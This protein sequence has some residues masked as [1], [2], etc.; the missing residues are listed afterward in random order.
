M[1]LQPRREV[2]EYGLLPLHAACPQL[3]GALTLAH[4]HAKL[5]ASSTPTAS[6]QRVIT[7]PAVAAALELTQT[8]TEAL[9]EVLAPLSVLNKNVDA[10][11][12]Q[13]FVHELSLFLFTQLFGREAQRP[14]S[15]EV[16]FLL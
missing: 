15:V 4:M 9:L 5:L 6:G 1:Q 14:D 16:R 3:D 8:Q 11:S 12:E 7:P 13:I 2:L 10:G